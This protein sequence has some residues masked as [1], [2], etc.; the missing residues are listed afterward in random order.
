MIGTI[1]RVFII[2]QDMIIIAYIVEFIEEELL[3]SLMDSL[4]DTHTH[5]YTHALSIHTH[6]L[7]VIIYYSHI[8]VCMF[9]R[10]LYKIEFMCRYTYYIAWTF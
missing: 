5:T 2:V 10:I 1:V 9:V 6:I 8:V 7:L 4:N 3:D